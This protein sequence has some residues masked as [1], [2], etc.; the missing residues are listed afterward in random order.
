M[1]NKNDDINFKDEWI[2]INSENKEEGRDARRKDISDVDVKG[3]EDGAKGVEDG[4]KGV[5]DGVKGVEDGGTKK[6]V[7][8]R[9]RIRNYIVDK[10]VDTVKKSGIP[11]DLACLILK[12][13]HFR[14]PF[15]LIVYAGFGNLTVAVMLWIFVMSV[16]SCFLFLDG[17]VLS[18][19]EYKL[20]GNSLNVMDVF[21]WMFNADLNYRNRYK[22][23]V[24][25]AIIYLISFFFVVFFRNGFSSE[26]LN[27]VLY[28]A[29]FSYL[30]SFFKSMMGSSMAGSS[31][32]GSSMLN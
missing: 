17:C 5:E 25:A 31:M 11:L 12:I 3:V 29:T 15:D 19:I 2:E 14:L 9:K 8:V 7:G 28:Y 16:F 10:C 23:T 21:L 30:P 13:F 4:T 24:I 1:D 26:N 27:K 20:T 32:A 18:V 6:R 22:A